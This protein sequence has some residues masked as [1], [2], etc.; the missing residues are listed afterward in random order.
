[1]EMEPVKTGEKLL[2]KK[3]FQRSFMERKE[4][5]DKLKLT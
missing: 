5:S 3:A 4:F 1:M 2:S